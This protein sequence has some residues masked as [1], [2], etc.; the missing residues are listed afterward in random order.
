MEMDEEYMVPIDY[1][2]Y[3]MNITDANIGPKEPEWKVLVDYKT[4]Y[5]V[6]D[7]SPDSMYELALRFKEDEDLA[8]DYLWN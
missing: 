7:L 6:K 2:V 1:K 8:I 5:K 3:W 4:D